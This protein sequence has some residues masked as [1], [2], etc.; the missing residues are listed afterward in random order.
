MSSRHILELS[1]EHVRSNSFVVYT[2]LILFGAF[3]FFSGFVFAEAT[4]GA[5]DH[6]GAYITKHC[7]RDCVDAGLLRL[8][9][10][11]ASASTKVDP[12][13]MLAVIQVESGFRQK[14]LNTTSG[15]SVGLTQVQVYW[16]RDKFRT[17]DYFD[18]IENVHAGAE[19]LAACQKKHRGNVE[20]SLWCY[21]GHQ[22]DGITR[23]AKK[24]LVALSRLKSS[25]IEV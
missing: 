25:L 17:K 4:N 9:L 6:L 8:A 24:V 16:H 3:V 12:L 7:K 15:R 11:E 13:L 19:I 22:E 14:A 5:N 20:R 2:Y 1:R 23:Y 21:N 10:S 18:V